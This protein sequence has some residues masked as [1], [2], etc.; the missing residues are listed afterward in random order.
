M[1]N[2]VVIV[3]G[4]LLAVLVASATTTTQGQEEIKTGAL[5][6]GSADFQQGLRQDLV[7]NSEGLVLAENA[8]SGRYT[9]A[10]IETAFP[11]NALVPSWSAE[12][13]EGTSVSV[14]IRTSKNGDR[15]GEWIQLLPN[16]DWMVPEDKDI[17]G[18]MIGVPGEDVTHGRLQFLVSFGR[19]AGQPSPILRGLKVTFFDSTQGPTAAELVARQEALDAEQIQQVDGYPKPSVVGRNTWCTDVD[20]CN[21]TNG[22]EY[23]P[24]THLIVHHTVTGNSSTN[25]AAIVRAIWRFHTFPDSPSCSGCRGWGD[26]GYN[27]LVDMNGVLYEGHLGGDDVVGTHAA[28]ANAGSMALA[29]IGTFTLAT[30]NP[31]G[32]SPPMAM[33][34]AAVELFA[35]KADQRDIDV[36]DSGYLPNVDWILPNLMGHRDVY[37]TTVC[38]GDQ[39]YALL[40]WFRDQVAQ[41]VTID[42]IYVDEL[43]AAFSKNDVPG[44]LVAS[45]NCGHNG[46]AYY[47]W[48]TQNSGA[49]LNKGEWRPVVPHSGFYELQAFIPYCITGAPETDGA[50]YSITHANGKSTVTISQEDHVRTWMSLGTYQF[51]AGNSAVIKLNNYTLTDS[52]LGV[53]FDALRLV[54]AN[55][56]PLPAIKSPKPISGTWL[57]SREVTFSWTVESGQAVEKTRLQVATDPGLTNKVFNQ[58]FAGLKSTQT[59]N[60]TQDYRQLFWQV[61]LTTSCSQIVYSSVQW[62]GVDTAPPTSAVRGVYLFENGRLLPAWP[63]QDDGV[64]IAYYNVDYR[65]EGDTSWVRWLTNYPYQSAYFVPPDG[66]DYWFRSQAVD[67]LGHVEPWP[68]TPDAGTSNAIPVH[69]AIIFPLV[70]R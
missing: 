46:H 1:N 45:D 57:D 32:I 4:L 18:Q 62:L 2:K 70:F 30:Q 19:Y 65:P 21:Y 67:A 35:W 25:W 13:P 40:P 60:F 51:N 50:T 29:L 27:Y 14:Q 58:E 28:G 39:A 61:R 56:C 6:L 20:N 68:A 42:T 55:S 63:G 52:N 15:W 47:A 54:P 26:I 66:R 41:K 37:G 38:P 59:I 24:V 17:L 49:T 11:F 34:N 12:T 22:L 36:H 48:S 69:R 10:V 3:I 7:V 44:W 5:S 33:R 9:S 8:V 53:W 64:G 16:D 43:S 23:E 31:P